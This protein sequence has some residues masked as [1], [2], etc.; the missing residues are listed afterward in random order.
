VIDTKLLRAFPGAYS[1]EPP[2]KGGARVARLAASSDLEG[3]TGQYYE[4]NAPVS[5]SP[6]SYHPEVR[7]AYWQIGTSM[8][9][10]SDW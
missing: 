2:E 9:G 10:L 5:S 3:R 6:L 1:G 8:T 4:D 7:E